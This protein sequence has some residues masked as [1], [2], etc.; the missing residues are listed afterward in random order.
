MYNLKVERLGV[1]LHE[2]L[3]RL[4]HDFVALLLA[5]QPALLGSAVVAVA[6]RCES[7]EVVGGAVLAHRHLAVRI[8]LLVE[9]V[10]LGV[11]HDVRLVLALG[12]EDGLLVLRHA[13]LVHQSLAGSLQHALCR[14]SGIVE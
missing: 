3:A 7:V 5:L 2:H 11:R 10:V 1:V 4:H 6:A 14:S 13:Q 8:L 9:A 12:V